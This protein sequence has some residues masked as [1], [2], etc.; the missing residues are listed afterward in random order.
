MCVQTT[1]RI[2]PMGVCACV[3]LRVRVRVCI[4]FRYIAHLAGDDQA[5]EDV[6]ALG[7]QEGI[8]WEHC[9]KVFRIDKSKGVLYGWGDKAVK[10]AWYTM[11]RNR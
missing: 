7:P 11:W 4:V 3:Y 9:L 5:I 6:R 10:S 1:L 2:F 8:A